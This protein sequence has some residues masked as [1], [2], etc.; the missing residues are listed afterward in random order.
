M[1]TES[2]REAIVILHG[3]SVAWLYLRAVMYRRITLVIC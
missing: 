2:D 3:V 1:T